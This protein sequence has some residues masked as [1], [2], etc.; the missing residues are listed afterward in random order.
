MNHPV[1][2]DKVYAEA[3]MALKK[4]PKEFNELINGLGG[5]T[6]GLRVHMGVVDAVVNNGHVLI[7]VENDEWESDISKKTISSLKV[8]DIKFP[9]L[10]GAIMDKNSLGGVVFFSVS[11]DYVSI[12]FQVVYPVEGGKDSRG[13][14]SQRIPMDSTVGEAVKDFGEHVDKTYMII[15][16]L[17]YISAFKKEKNRVKENITNKLKAS[18]RRALPSHKIHTVMVRQPTSSRI[19][20]MAGGGAKSSMSWIV[21]GHWRN[22]WYSKLEEHKPKWVDS[23]FKGKGKEEIS[24]VYKVS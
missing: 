16:I 7:D 2:D 17:M 14:L 18:K 8:K 10:A 9:F 13:I 24:K 3:Y 6:M 21:K 23:Y 22:Q 12:S 15:S 11:N 4:K 1:Y 20:D 19:G 5:S